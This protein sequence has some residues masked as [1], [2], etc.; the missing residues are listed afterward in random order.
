MENLP[1]PRVTFAPLSEGQVLRYQ[2][3]FGYTSEDLQ[4]I[5]SPMALE[6]KEPVGSMGTDVATLCF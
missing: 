4:T 5:I 1:E 3:A 2:K 6:G